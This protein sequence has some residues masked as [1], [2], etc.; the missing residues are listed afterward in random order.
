M[1]P[2]NQDIP[3]AVGCSLHECWLIA[4][5]PP[6]EPEPTEYR[7]SNLPADTRLR[8]LVP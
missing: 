3:R 5:W 8:K 1:R 2:V 6:H 4:E 7:L